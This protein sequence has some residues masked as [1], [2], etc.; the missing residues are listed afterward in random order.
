[1]IACFGEILW[2]LLPDRELPGGAP[3]NVAY[4]LHKLGET[5][6]LLTRIGNDEH[7]KRLLEILQQQGIDTGYIQFDAEL[8]TG[9]VHAMPDAG[10]EMHYDIVHPAAWDNIQVE[11]SLEKLVAEADYFVFGSLAARAAQSRKTLF[12]LLEAASHKV[13]DINLRPPYFDRS[14]VEE[15]MHSA[16]IVK[17]NG[18]EL[19]LIAGWYAPQKSME[20]GMQ[21]IRDR[22]AVDSV[23]VTLGGDGAVVNFQGHYFS[24]PGFPVEVADTIGSGDAFLAGF[25]ARILHHHSPENALEFA[26]ALGAL[27]TS[28][29]GGWPAYGTDEVETIIA[30][31]YNP[32]K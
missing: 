1:M 5:P 8:A 23:I 19:S 16:D 9:L 4:H 21:L 29:H 2:D 25:L 30:A 24:H 31:G 22:F 13:L 28:K 10:G 17:M 26:S 11:A 15:L 32:S 6:A 27:V 12:R 14:I 20:A 18:S 3:M 7:G